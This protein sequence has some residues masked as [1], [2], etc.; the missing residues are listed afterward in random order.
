MNSSSEGVPSP[1]PFF[2]LEGGLA[3]LV[4]GIL[5]ILGHLANLGG[6]AGVG[7][8]TGMSLVMAG[9]AVMVLALVGLHAKQHG[10]AGVL[11][12]VGTLLAI[13]GTVAVSAV[14]FVEIAGASGVPVEP[15]FQAPAAHEI[16]AAGPIIFALGM[17]LLGAAIARSLVFPV[18]MGVLLIVGTIVFGIGT[19]AG[20][21]GPYLSVLGAIVTGAGFILLG[22]KLLAP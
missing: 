2:R 8:V 17:F 11:G 1:S 15:V 3:A 18:Y 6:P 13:L 10:P 20:P 4:T 16:F 7:T 9:H 21:A 5:L 19:L 12:W 22:A 14:V